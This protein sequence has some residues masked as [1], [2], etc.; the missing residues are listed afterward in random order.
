MLIGF[1]VGNYRSFKDV[2]TL[3]MVAAEDACGNDE[4][5]K[6]NVFKVNQQFSLLKSAAIYG[7]NAVLNKDVI[8]LENKFKGTGT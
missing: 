2:V 3:S 4:L 8:S 5:D 7:A 1:S 6:N